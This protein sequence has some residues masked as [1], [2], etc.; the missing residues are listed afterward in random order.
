MTEPEEAPAR[1]SPA[2]KR[3]LPIIFFISVCGVGGAALMPPALPTIADYFGV[4]RTTAA[5]LLT[6][7]TLPGI[8][9]APVAGALSDRYGRRQVMVP[10]L[11]IFGLAGGL[12]A[13]APSF[14]WILVARFVQG[15][16]SAGMINLAVV[17]LGD[18]FDGPQ[19][20][21]MIGYNA[22][23]LTLGTTSFPS[24]GGFLTAINWRWVF[25]V[26]W[27]ALPVALLAAWFLPSRTAVR[28]DEVEKTRMRDLLAV[29]S[30]RRIV[31]RGGLIFVV[32]FGAILTAGPLMLASRFDASPSR[33]GI[34]L[35]AAAVMSMIGAVNTARVREHLRPSQTL[36]VS[37][38]F[39]AVGLILMAIGGSYWIVLVGFMV[40]GVGEGLSIALLQ[41][42]ATEVAP[43]GRRG[44]VVALWVSSARIGQTSGPIAAKAGIDSFGM[45]IS[46]ALF[47]LLSAAMAVG[48]MVNGA[49]D[50]EGESA[51]PVILEEVDIAPGDSKETGGRSTEEGGL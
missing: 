33:I 25:L 11:L 51:G 14:T 44:T 28:S 41:T 26:F 36:F 5:L 42:R 39:Y 27:F 38:V 30:V 24:L 29:P 49:A 1:L 9:L 50:D 8:F 34:T 46:L 16:G 15:I 32:I 12:A 18:L 7:N 19:R 17:M 21:R 48:S 3:S 20:T 37:A 10:S 2:Q 40:C 43:P 47:S 4:E 22:G 6:V 23:A 13:F 45:T 31:V 35:T